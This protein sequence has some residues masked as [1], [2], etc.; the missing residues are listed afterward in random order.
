MADESPKL[1][2]RLRRLEA[3]DPLFK[4]LAQSLDIRDVWAQ[5]AAV[6]RERSGRS[7]RWSFRG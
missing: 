5:V 1:D 3:L 2:Q 6:A 7:S 4:T